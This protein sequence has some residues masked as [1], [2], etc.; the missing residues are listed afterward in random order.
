MYRPSGYG[1]VQGVIV[2][3]NPHCAIRKTGAAL[4]MMATTAVFVTFQGSSSGAAS[5]VPFFSCMS[6]N[7]AAATAKSRAAAAAKQGQSSAAAAAMHAWKIVLRYYEL[8]RGH[9]FNSA[10][11]RKLSQSF[12]LDLSAA[13]S[14]SAAVTASASTSPKQSLL[15]TVG[16]IIATHEPYRRSDDAKFKAFVC[17]GLK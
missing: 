1:K 12:G 5:L 2:T 10:P 3:P 7:S 11:Q 15:A 16:Q 14:A 4:M 6:R 17:A 13:A 8:K 9:E